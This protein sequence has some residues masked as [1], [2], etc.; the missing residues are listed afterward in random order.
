MNKTNKGTFKFI[1][2][3]NP[4]RI[5]PEKAYGKK[6]LNNTIRELIFILLAN[7]SS[8]KKAFESTYK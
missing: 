1:P 3:S 5:A 4:Q 8:S 6:H 7:N 2:W